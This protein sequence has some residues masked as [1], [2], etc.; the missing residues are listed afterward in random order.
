ML[1]IGTGKINVKY[2]PLKLFFN[3][4]SENMAWKHIY[5][6]VIILTFSNADFLNDLRDRVKKSVSIFNVIKVS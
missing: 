1:N 2:S 3:E 6:L 4:K 5:I